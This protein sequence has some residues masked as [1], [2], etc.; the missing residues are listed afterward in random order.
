VEVIGTGAY[1]YARAEADELAL[2]GEQ[3]GVLVFPAA[4]W[5]TSNGLRAVVPTWFLCMT[6]NVGESKGVAWCEQIA[7]LAP[8]ESAIKTAVQTTMAILRRQR[9]DPA[10]QQQARV[11][12][13]GSA[14]DALM[15]ITRTAVPDPAFQTTSVSPMPGNTSGL[16]AV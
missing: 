6:L 13:P 11:Q 14:M 4:T 8:S 10:A 1:E 15:G 16:S 12:Q 5:N 7:P 3:F 2:D 9:D